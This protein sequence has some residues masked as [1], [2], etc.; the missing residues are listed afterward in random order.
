MLYAVALGLMVVSTQDASDDVEHAVSSEA[1]ATGDL[2]RVMSGLEPA[3]RDHLQREL[4]GYVLLV[5]NDE[6]PATQRA[7]PS[8][9]TWT[10]MDRLSREIY[11]FQ[12][13][14]PREERVYPQLTHEMEEVLDARRDRLFLGQQGVG[15]VTWAIIVLGG[16]IT[17]GFAAFFRMENTA[18]RSCSPRWPRRCSA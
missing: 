1:N 10:A 17:V 8:P 18:R 11:T 4:A 14:T 9:R 2:F 5:V 15:S 3:S 16:L 7:E 12:P 6:W 13:S